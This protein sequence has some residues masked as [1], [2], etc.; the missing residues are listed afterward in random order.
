MRGN[1]FLVTLCGTLRDIFV[2]VATGMCEQVGTGNHVTTELRARG[3][4]P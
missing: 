3:K 4:L 2:L 1:G